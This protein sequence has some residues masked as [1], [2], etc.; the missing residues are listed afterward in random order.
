MNP[1]IAA[2]LFALL[3]GGVATAQNTR[4][5]LFLAPGAESPVGSHEGTLHGYGA[6]AGGE[7]LLG[8]HFGVGAEIGGM[9]PGKGK[10][11]ETI[12]I[13]SAN[14]Y[15]HLRREKSFDP[16]VVGGY[17]MFFRDFT[18]N[19]GNVGVGANYW[20]HENVG[21]LLEGR[22]HYAKIQ[23]VPTHIWEFRI[24]LTFR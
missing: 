21:L 20:F 9:A 19:G 14:A 16:F 8:S 22:D 1:K 6:G 2:L 17:S 13:F 15:G 11:S 5:Y 10:A 3:W 18:A 24:G 12:G 4:E 23:G 7:L